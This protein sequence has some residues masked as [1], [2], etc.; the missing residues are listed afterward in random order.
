VQTKPGSYDGL[1]HVGPVFINLVLC[2]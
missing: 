2:S 1:P